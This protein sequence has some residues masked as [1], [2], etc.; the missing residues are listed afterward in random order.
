MSRPSPTLHCEIIVAIVNNQGP[1]AY[2]HDS[3]WEKGTHAVQEIIEQQRC[4]QRAIQYLESTCWKGRSIATL[5]TDTLS[6][7]LHTYGKYKS[8]DA[9]DEALCCHNKGV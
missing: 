4:S 9:E 8:D 1:R 6:G 3:A 2:R 7:I 5:L